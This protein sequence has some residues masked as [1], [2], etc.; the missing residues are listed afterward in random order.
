MVIDHL[1]RELLDLC[2]LRFLQRQRAARHFGH[3][4]LGHLFDGAGVRTS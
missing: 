2:V 1:L 4:G 3:V